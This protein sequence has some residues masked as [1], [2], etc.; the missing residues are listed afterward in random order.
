MEDLIEERKWP[1]NR[2]APETAED[3]TPHGTVPTLILSPRRGEDQGE[4]ERGGLIRGAP[5]EKIVENNST[6]TIRPFYFCSR[7][8]PG[9]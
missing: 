9:G 1:R 3:G 8:I 2:K 5:W 6:E 4:G 7:G